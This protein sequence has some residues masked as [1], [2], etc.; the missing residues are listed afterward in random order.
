MARDNGNEEACRSVMLRLATGD[1]RAFLLSLFASTRSDELALMSL[2]EN[3]KQSFIAMQ[4]DAQSRQ[5]RAAFP[6]AESSIILRDE[7]P[8][9]RLLLDRG[10][11]EFTLVDIALLP[12]HRGTGVGT[13]L[14][15]DIAKDAAAD[16]KS[17][18]LHVI[19][20]SAAK[21]LYERLGFSRVGGDDAYLEMLWAPPVSQKPKSELVISYRLSPY[22]SFVENRLIPGLLHHGVSHRL[23]GEVLEPGE[24]I[25]SLLLAM[26]T[27]TPISLSDENLKSY[28]EDGEHL[29]QLIQWGFLIPYGDDPLDRFM[30]HYVA[31][32]IQNPALV[33]RANDGGFWIARTSMAQQM[34]SPKAGESPE[35]IEEPISQT[36][37]AIFK[38]ADGTRTLKEI[39]ATL[40]GTDGDKISADFRQTLD[41]LTNQERQMIKFTQRREDLENP[42]SPVNIV[43][44]TLFHSARWSE[45][46]DGA[47]KPVIDFHLEGIEDASWEFD[48]IEPTV[49]HA[50]RFACEALG[51]L[52]YGSRFAVSTLRPEVVPLLGQKQ[53]IE[54]LEVGGGTG[55]FARSFI[56]QSQKLK[57]EGQTQAD[58]NYH[59]LDLS[60]ELMQNQRK[61]L[62][63]LMPADH[64]FHQD[65]TK[66]SLPD[67][68]F[69]LIVSNEVIADFPM[70][71]V[72]RIA[73]ESETAAARWEGSGATYLAKYGLE[74]SD[75]PDS[76]LLNA[77]AFEF[78]ERCFE[79]LVP[80][81]TLLVSEYGSP[82][83]YP[84][85]AFQLSHEEFSIHFG[86]LAAC[87]TR[88]GF[89]CRLLMLKDFLG[90]DDSVPALTGQQEHF[91]ILNHVLR[92]YGLSLPYA[93][94]SQAEFEK[95]FQTTVEQIELCGFSF[96]PISRGYHFGPKIEEFMILIMTKPLI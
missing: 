68:A 20:S 57:D 9:G 12:A 47:A 15:Q 1:D 8:I 18:R 63:H 75:A 43:P 35:I 67:R 17:I 59:I 54:V 85:Q 45:S 82:Y 4:F 27:G 13:A 71:T 29:R 26:Q 11:L 2:D 3:Q 69:D 5:Y 24:R 37:V 32:P 51:G 39:L 74:T 56:Q 52:D 73:P 70:A 89:E 93:V 62:S 55:T 81:G 36:G 60:P 33:Y 50:F 77:G 66:F 61:L 22:V 34:F 31:R 14:I 58:V 80:G 49:N 78:I 16:G 30:N 44:R 38:I 53:R 10:K 86:H 41:F 6:D 95:Q 90:L 92:K 64:H 19:A 83:R 88:V 65:A 96:L 72:N 40:G 87:A 42:Y 21:R 76:F 79:H 46:A 7:V 23:T 28:G 91:L 84:A 25:R 48:L 94:I